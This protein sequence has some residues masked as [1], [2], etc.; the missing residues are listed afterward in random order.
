M[1][2]AEIKRLEEAILKQRKQVGSSKRAAEK[3]L[4]KLEIYDILVPKGSQ[5]VVIESIDNR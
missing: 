2:K 5:K 3:L 1:S 4:K